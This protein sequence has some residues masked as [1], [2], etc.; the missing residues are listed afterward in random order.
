MGVPK[1]WSD[2]IKNFSGI[3]LQGAKRPKAD[4][5]YIDFNA[6]VYNALKL[7]PVSKNKISFQNS[8]ID[9]TVTGMNLLIDAVGP[10]ELVYIAVDGPVPAGKM[11]QQRDRR[12][13]SIISQKMASEVAENIYG[14]GKR[15]G[16]FQNLS[17]STSNISPGTFFMEKL[18]EK[19]LASLKKGGRKFIF[20][21]SSVP[22]EGEHKIINY[23]KSLGPNNKVHV[24]DSPDNDLIILLVSIRMK[25]Y[26]LRNSEHDQKLDTQEHVSY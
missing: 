18:E 25:L 21:G 12:Y 23:I 13:K 15:D 24:V 16:S 20:S 10:R 3:L 9:Q 11:Y 2:I 26:L 5:L 19:I 7:V 6:L 14:P 17:W 1:L 22:G 4:N 8:L